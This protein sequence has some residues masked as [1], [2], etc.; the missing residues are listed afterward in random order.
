[1]SQKIDISIISSGASYADARLHRLTR[2]LLRAGLTVE[3]FAP[4]S[5]K[6]APTNVQ[7]DGT[8]D[9]PQL[10][11]RTPLIGTAWKNTSLLARYYRSRIFAKIGRAHV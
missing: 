8:S 6:D 1:M 2:A 10:I 3:I 11:L 4:G 5:R 9:A 7:V